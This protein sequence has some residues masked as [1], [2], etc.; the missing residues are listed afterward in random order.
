V[1][2]AQEQSASGRRSRRRQDRD[3]Q[4]FARRINDATSGRYGIRRSFARHGRTLAG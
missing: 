1:P 2:P 4:G 3:R